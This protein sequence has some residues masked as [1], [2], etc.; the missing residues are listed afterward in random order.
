MLGCKY[1]CIDR[2]MQRAGIQAS[3]NAG[4]VYEGLRRGCLDA[5]Q[6]ELELFSQCHV[7]SLQH[8]HLQFLSLNSTKFCLLD[9]YS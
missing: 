7:R 2:C 4:A 5:L 9:R 6:L 1:A 8:P 3:I